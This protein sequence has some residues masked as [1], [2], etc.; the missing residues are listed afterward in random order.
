MVFLPTAAFGNSRFLMTVGRSGEVMGLFYP[1]IDHAQNVR[2]CLFGV[3]FADSPEGRFAWSWDDMWRIEQGFS[4]NGDTEFASSILRTVLSNP[5]TGLVVELVDLVPADAPAWVRQVS[6]SGGH[7][8]L[9]VCQYFQLNLG[10]VARGNAVHVYPDERQCIQRYRETTF[11]ITAD[12]GFEHQCGKLAGDLSSRT[13]WDMTHGHLSGQEMDIGQVDL[14]IA[15]PLDFGDPRSPEGRKLSSHTERITMVVAAGGNEPEARDRARQVLS[16]SFPELC[17]G[18]AHGARSWL[19]RGPQTRD[20]ELRTPLQRSLLVL[21]DLVDEGT[22]AMLAAP[23]FDPMY[24]LS[25]GYGYCWPRDAAEGALALAEAGYVD[26]AERVLRWCAGTQLETGHWYQRYWTTG[27]P[28][29]AWCVYPDFYQL[30]QT[31]ATV[32]AMCRLAPMLPEGAER[33]QYVAAVRPAVERGIAAIDRAVADDGLHE[34]AADLWERFRGVFSYTSA[35]VYRAWLSAKETYGLPASKAARVKRAVLERFWLEDERR[36]ARGLDYDGN[37]DRQHDS[38][39]LGLIEPFGLLD[40]RDETE[41]AMAVGTLEA[42]ERCLSLTIRGRRCILR[43]E[44]DPYMGG[45][46]GCVNT[47]WT[48]RVHLAVAE[49]WLDRGRSDRALDHV[50]MARQ[51]LSTAV[52]CANPTGQLPE[53]IVH[54]DSFTYWAAPHAW[55]SGLFVVTVMKLERL[56]GLL[57][58]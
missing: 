27:L 48:A 53:L 46:A 11:C 33:D 51:H 32:D 25:G 36:F 40:L 34:R 9:K 3:Y 19:V 58:A 4:N 1:H 55:A 26:T 20:A 41:F 18:V 10:D 29:S 38:S 17:E 54:M 47:L 5:R 8:R 16:T 39:V 31:A 12:R 57:S 30:D 21:R 45:A 7:G 15:F 2:E 24:E 37:I 13:K 52:A 43:H 6:V 50:G 44:H 42:V 23:E 14:A 35:A 28:A 49:A 22:G 56:R